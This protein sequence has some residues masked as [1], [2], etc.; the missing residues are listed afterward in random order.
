MTHRSTRRAGAAL[1]VAALALSLTAC[2]S[3]SGAAA[4]STTSG[5]GKFAT[6]VK[7][8]GIAW[9][10]RMQVGLDQQAKAIGAT[11]T[12]VGP[13]DAS[14]EKQ[15]K[16]VQDL[17]AQKPKAI[18]VVPL[19]PQALEGVLG[20]AR[21]AGIKVITHEAPSQT[22]TD[23]DIEAFDNAAYGAHMMEKLAACMGG[24]GKYVTFVGSL[25]AESH[26]AWAKSE[27]DTAT[28]NYPGIQRVADPV[29]SK[30]DLDNTYNKTKEILA[31]Y[32]DIKGFLG[33]AAS[34]VA[35]IGRAI[36]EAGLQDKTCVMGTSIPSTAGKYLQDG[37]VDEIFFW[38]P[39]VTGQVLITLQDKLSKGEKV[40]AGTNLGIPGYENLQP[41]T[42]S[43][44][45]LHGN[46]WVDV[47]KDNMA[48]YDF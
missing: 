46:A 14:P 17:I 16:I 2:A 24:Q 33:S 21:S 42:G 32:P 8:Q 44:H 9:F 18:A 12:M 10:N 43:K 30:E 20:Q 15:V 7:L 48:E 38:D 40:E 19:S 34:D 27:L 45:A 4:G 5:S 36:S 1:T 23:L 25:T 39:K 3:H 13:D 31:K 35:G 26:M 29:E 22:N 41:V 47:T 6:V 28:K 11:S 37:S